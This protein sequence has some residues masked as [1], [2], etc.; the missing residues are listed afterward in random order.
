MGRSFPEYAW[1]LPELGGLPYTTRVHDITIPP[2]YICG[3]SLTPSTYGSLLCSLLDGIVAGYVVK[4][5]TQYGHVSVLTTH[6][7]AAMPSRSRGQTSKPYLDVTGST[8]TYIYTGKTDMSQA[9]VVSY[10]HHRLP[11][12]ARHTKPTCIRRKPR[13]T[14]PRHTI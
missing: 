2:E 5:D 10:I 12:R 11:R 3:W 4:M 8:H 14:M 6:E 13:T 9:R 1:M 7:P